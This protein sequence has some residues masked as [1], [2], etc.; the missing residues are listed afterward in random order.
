MPERN[1]KFYASFTTA[2]CLA[3]GLGGI[4]FI[5]AKLGA[6]P[7]Y[8]IAIDFIAFPILIAVVLYVR[9]VKIATC[10]EF[11]VAKK[12]FAAQTGLI[13]GFLLFAISGV[14]PFMFREA[15]HHFIGG[16]GSTEDGYQIGRV[17]GMAPFLVG[18][19]AGQVLAWMK[20]R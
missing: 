3:G 5:W 18:L 16:L 6:I 11:T 10:D 2:I 8:G 15:Y 20:F 4:N 17:L 13:I 1:W 14:F 7:A 12:R 9:R 19:I